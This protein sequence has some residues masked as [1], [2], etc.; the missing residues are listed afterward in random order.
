MDFELDAD[1]LELQAN[2]R[3]VVTGECPPALVRAVGSGDDDGGRFWKTLVGLG[4]PSL[5]IPVVDGGLGASTAELGV[6]LEQLGYAADPTPSL[7][8][9]S[10]YVPVIRECA[11]AGERS[12]LL[13][14]VC[15]GGAGAVA[16]EASDVTVRR[17]GEGW[18]LDGTCLLYTSDAADE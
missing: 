3:G 7:A 13:R 12:S 17:D 18:V 6:V 9:M 5:T 2:A 15:D 8:T 16:F 11:P 14:A 10:H 1:Q 4:W